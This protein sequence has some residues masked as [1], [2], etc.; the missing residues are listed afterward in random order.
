MDANK[1]NEP[2]GFN[3]TIYHEGFKF[4]RKYI[5][6]KIATYWCCHNR[7][8]NSDC[9]AKIQINKKGNVIKTIGDHHVS[10]YYKK[11]DTRKA[12]CY[13]DPK[14]PK[15]DDFECAPDL[16][17]MML[18]RAE[19][20]ALEDISLP[21]KKVHQQVLRGV[22]L[23]HKV[24][25]G[26]SDQ[27]IMNRVRNSRSNLNGNDVFR[28][29]EMDTISRVKNSNLFFLQFNSTF[30]NEYDGKLER[31]LGLE[32]LHCSEFSEVARGCLSMVPSSLYQNHFINV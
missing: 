29:I 1:E 18:N 21:P 28:T 5:G 23:K 17:H 27:K 32:T 22:Q 11:A 2:S 16:T 26:A 12:L 3:G 20:I 24:F 6:K 8:K 25:K 13:L 30:P 7:E 31:I 9:K 15:D 10:C 14:V 4:H 19:E